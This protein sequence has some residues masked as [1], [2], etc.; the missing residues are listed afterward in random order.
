MAHA[1]ETIEMMQAEPM[2]KAAPAHMSVQAAARAL[3]A[4]FGNV[5]NR[6]TRTIV[7][8]AQSGMTCAEYDE[9]EQQAIGMAKAADTASGWQPPADAKGRAKYGPKQS[10]MATQA[11]YRR[12]VFGAARLNLTCIV[13][14]PESGIVNPD[15]FPSFMAAYKAASAWLKNQGIDWQGR[16]T[17]DLR[18]EKEQRQETAAYREARDQVEKDMPQKPGES[19]GEWQARIADTIAATIASNA[20]KARD[21]A[22]RAAAA[23]IVEQFGTIDALLVAD[24]ILAMTTPAEE[25]PM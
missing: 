22:I 20:D 23:K 4:E 14:I 24:A 11:S 5:D 10:S 15:T 7:G 18:R 8:L 19:I 12:Q 25:A 21:K 17:D 2:S 16:A 6:P 3:F 9:A 1:L 13:S